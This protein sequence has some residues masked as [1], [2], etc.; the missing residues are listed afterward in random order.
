[1]KIVRR[2]LFFSIVIMF[3]SVLSGCTAGPK[4][5]KSSNGV[6]HEQ[7]TSYYNKTKN[8]ISFDSLDQ[9]ITS[10]GRLPKK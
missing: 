4:V 7:G 3:V 1:M 5:K 9:C 8:F 6:C 2:F 10:G